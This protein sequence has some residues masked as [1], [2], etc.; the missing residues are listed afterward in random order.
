MLPM[1]TSVGSAIALLVTSLSAV[2][3]GIPPV[4][5]LQPQAVAAKPSLP[6]AV[7]Q[8]T[9]QLSDLEPEVGIIRNVQQG[10]LMCYITFTDEFGKR[11]QVGA[12]FELCENPR[13]YLNQRVRLVYGIRSVSDC[14]S[15]EPCGKSRRTHLVIRMDPVDQAGRPVSTTDTVVLRNRNWTITVGNRNSWSG[16]NGTG[17]LTYRGCNTRGECLSLTGG[18]LTCRDGVCLTTWRNGAFSYTLN[19]PIHDGSISA[20]SSLTVRRNNK[21]LQQIVG[22]K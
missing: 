11:R 16:V 7:P 12:T 14:Q 2:S 4:Q 1:H 6:T 18:T 21:I 20:T 15:A 5:A 9:A 17:N 8:L 19:T 22:L 3:P 10:D 13:Q